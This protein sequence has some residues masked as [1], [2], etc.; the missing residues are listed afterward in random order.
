MLEDTTAPCPFCDSEI[1]VRIMT[2][3]KAINYVVTDSCP[4][5]SK[6]ADRIESALNRSN[7]KSQHV[8]TEK[9]YIKLDPRG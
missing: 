4:Y 6:S 8:R 1:K 3:G 9:S 5:C 2:V 7:R